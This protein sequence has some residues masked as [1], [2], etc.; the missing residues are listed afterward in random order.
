MTVNLSQE[1]VQAGNEIENNE[2]RDRMVRLIETRHG[3]ILHG[4][5]SRT[6]DDALRDGR[7]DG[8]SHAATYHLSPALVDG[9]QSRS[10]PTF[11]IYEEDVHSIAPVEPED[12]PV[13]Q[14]IW[15]PLPN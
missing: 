14:V 12:V 1:S 8:R 10:T 9:S 11:I 13:R 6:P 3:R 15:L 7:G 4:V 2:L 5:L